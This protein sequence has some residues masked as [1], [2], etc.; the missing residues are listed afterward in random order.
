L[1]CA[2]P[3][4]TLNAFPDADGTA[5]TEQLERTVAAHGGRAR[6][7]DAGVMQVHVTDVWAAKGFAPKAYTDGVGTFTLTYDYALDKGTMEFDDADLVWGHDSVEGWVEAD[8]ERVYKG[9]DDATFFVPTTAY[10]LALPA[11]LTDDGANGWALPD[12][13][14]TGHRRVLVTFDPGVGVVSDRYVVHVDPETERMTRLDFTVLD[15]GKSVAAT[16]WYTWN[17]Q[18]LPSEIVLDASSPFT[19]TPLHTFTMTDWQHGVDVDA[20]RFEKPDAR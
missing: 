20:A 17:D 10:F 9:V 7:L 12:D 1:A 2:N 6:L 3:I 14:E 5:G 15:A 11:R 19:M 4:P 13:E 16:A 8:G 18:D